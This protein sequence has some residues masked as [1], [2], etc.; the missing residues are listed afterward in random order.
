[1]LVEPGPV[2]DKQEEVIQ[3]EEKK[4]QKEGGKVVAAVEKEKVNVGLYLIVIMQY[5]VF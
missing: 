5:D 1:M 4:Q 2:Q 3:W